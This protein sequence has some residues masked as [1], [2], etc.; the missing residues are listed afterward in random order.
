MHPRV[1]TLVTTFERIHR[2]RMAGLP[3]VHPRL[4][5]AA[6]G[7]HPVQADGAQVLQGVL[8]TPWFM[9]LVQLPWARQDQT[10]AVGRS[11]SRHFGVQRF[12]CLVA[13]EEDLGRYESCALF[14]PMQEFQDQAHAEQVALEVL[15]AL[16]DAPS[17]QSSPP[18][19]ASA[20]P[21]RRL[22]LLGRGLPART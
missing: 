15:R 13:H 6:F 3:V 4:R 16:R 17:P 10:D 8:V 2:E 21:S 1:Q 11:V 5:V 22:F 18:Q 12:D 19:A 7:F 14:S 9:S 20:P